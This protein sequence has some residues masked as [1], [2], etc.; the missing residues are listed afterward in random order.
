MHIAYIVHV[1][2]VAYTVQP[3]TLKHAF[4]ILKHTWMITLLHS[5]KHNKLTLWSTSINDKVKLVQT[6]HLPYF[7]QLNRED[8]FLIRYSDQHTGVVSSTI[9][10]LTES[11]SIWRKPL[12]ISW[13]TGSSLFHKRK[14]RKNTNCRSVSSS[15]RTLQLH[16]KMGASRLANHM[17]QVQ[18]CSSKFLPRLLP[19][20]GLQLSITIIILLQSEKLVGYSRKL[21]KRKRR[22]FCQSSASSRT[23]WI[24]S[25]RRT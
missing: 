21:S 22:M 9:Q 7:H 11:I 3:E 23:Y 24:Y 2:T 4:R 17:L 14:S 8:T 20:A 10:S 15:Y 13:K 25:K 1:C 6:L 12:K 19:V 5:E 18:Y 16:L